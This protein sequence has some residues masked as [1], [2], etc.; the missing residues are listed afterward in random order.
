MS[1]FLRAIKQY[2]NQTILILIFLFASNSSSAQ[3]LD[4]VRVRILRDPKIFFGFDARRSF[5]EERQVK[6]SG[7]RIGVD[8]GRVLRL[9]VGLYFL[10]QPLYTNQIVNEGT[11]VEDTLI[12]RYN[13]GYFSWF[14]EYV[15]WYNKHWEFT[16]T[17]HFGLGS[18]EKVSQFAVAGLPVVKQKSFQLLEPSI[19]AQYRFFQW[20]GLGAAYGYRFVLNNN[21]DLQN[22][23]NDHIYYLKLK[24]YLGVI[25]KAIFPKKETAESFYFN[26]SQRVPAFSF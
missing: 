15:I 23:I 13:F 4:S 11:L 22:L 3:Y 25:W 14:A 1:K 20:I 26:R 6:I 12:T 9:G 8:M 19:G 17:L 18:G 21:P 24:I 10:E 7:I 2:S 16:S 5:V